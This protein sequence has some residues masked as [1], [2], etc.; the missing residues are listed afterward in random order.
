M[1]H[2]EVNGLMKGVA[3][4]KTS[5][6]YIYIMLHFKLKSKLPLKDTDK[7][8]RNET[9][10]TGRQCG[11]TLARQRCKGQ[12]FESR[13]LASKLDGVQLALASAVRFLPFSC[14]RQNKRVENSKHQKQAGRKVESLM[15]P[16]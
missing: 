5:T 7:M 4:K 12:L 6:P 16:L 11:R 13:S 1:L 15:C 3:T 10:I 9:L 8:L 14:A 2:V